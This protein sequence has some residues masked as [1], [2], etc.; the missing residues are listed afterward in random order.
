MG[1]CKSRMVIFSRFLKSGRGP[2]RSKTIT[3]LYDENFPTFVGFVRGGHPE[4]GNKRKVKCLQHIYLVSNFGA[5]E[6]LM[7]T[8]WKSFMITK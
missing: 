6:Q 7:I 1:L 5:G 4:S 8:R 2:K 3:T